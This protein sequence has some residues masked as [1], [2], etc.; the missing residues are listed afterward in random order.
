MYKRTA[1]PVDAKTRKST[2]QQQLVANTKTER[3]EVSRLA[4]WCHNIHSR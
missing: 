2:E 1:A 4:I 3:R